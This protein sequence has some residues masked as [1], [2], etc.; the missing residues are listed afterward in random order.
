[1][2]YAS[3]TGTEWNIQ[4]VDT[5]FTAREPGYLAVDSNCNPHISYRRGGLNDPNATIV[6]AT[7]NATDL[8]QKS[9]P[10]FPSL[11]VTVTTA[12]IGVAVTVAVVYVWKKR[13]QLNP[14]QG[15]DYG[16][17]IAISLVTI[18]TSQILF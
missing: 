9:S 14:K 5:N 2:Q 3:W 7:A 6:Y 13:K 15:S 16:F 4:T 17:A 18:I 8:E 1:M 11:A 12:S 10:S